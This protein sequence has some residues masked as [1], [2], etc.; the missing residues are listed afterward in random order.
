MAKMIKFDLPIDGVKVA[1]L[2]DL[3]DHFTIEIIE[4]FRS[5]LLKRWLRSQRLDCK[6]TSVESLA[7]NGDDATILAQLCEIFEVE[8]DDDVI[9]AA[10]AE[11][12]GVPGM[13][14]LDSTVKENAIEAI[15]ATTQALRRTRSDVD[16]AQPISRIVLMKRLISGDVKLAIDKAPEAIGLL[17]SHFARVD[18]RVRLDKKDMAAIVALDEL[19][20]EVTAVQSIGGIP[21]DVEMMTLLLGAL[22]AAMTAVGS[23]EAHGSG[24]A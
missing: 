3:Q 7:S 4:H 22:R 19:R 20:E 1:T 5:G 6:L 17:L 2:D 11:A 23:P 24:G 12:T 14:R 10:I 16:L 21:L 18:V 8:A 13:I 9:A 15:R